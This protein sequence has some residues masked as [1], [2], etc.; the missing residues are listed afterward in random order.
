MTQIISRDDLL[1]WLK[2]LLGS[3]AVIAPARAAGETMFCRVSDVAEIDL[4]YQTSVVSPKGWFFPPSETLFTVQ[5]KNG[6][7]DIA[8]ARKVE[9]AV[10]FGI[11]PCD[12]RGIALMDRPFLQDPA[13]PIYRERRERT[14]LVGLS[15]PKLGPACFCSSMGSAPDDS[16]YVDI[17][18]TQVEGGYL[19]QTVSEK[20]KALLSGAR[21][22]ESAI[23][24]PQV[25]APAEVPTAGLAEAAPLV[26]RDQYWERLGDRCLQCNLCAY[27]CPT[28]YCFDIRDFSDDGVQ[29]ERVRTWESCQSRGFIRLAGGHDPRPTKGARLRQRFYHKLHYFPKEFG[30]IAC[31]GCG[32]CVRS[33]PVNIDIREV[34]ADMQG[35]EK[36][37]AKR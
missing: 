30:D 5:Q 16:R 31:T 27:V 24:A 13:D 20:G 1:S 4:D 19:V 17:L 2:Q 6:A 14:V 8:Q 22:S 26:F 21:T 28:C 32:R 34:I 7:T 3:H 35:L 10:I 29:V 36:Q 12:A 23:A 18:L 37:S 15:C 9:D 33:C 11:R 25:S